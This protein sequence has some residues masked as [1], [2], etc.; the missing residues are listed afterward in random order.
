MMKTITVSLILSMLF[1][2]CYTTNRAIERPVEPVQAALPAESPCND[3]LYVQLKEKAL[4]DMTE[5]EYEYFMRK[6][7]EC[8]DYQRTQLTEQA[9]QEQAQ[10]V[11]SGVQAWSTYLIV[12][13]LISL[14]LVAYVYSETP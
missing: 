8:S 7:Q 2:G 3:S 6:D 5:R 10:A 4:E 9:D 12:S 11:R 1:M 13:A 14:A